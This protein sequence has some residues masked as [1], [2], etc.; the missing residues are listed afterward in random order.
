M[1]T[2]SRR[3]AAGALALAVAATL[4]VA[5][6]AGATHVKGHQIP[7]SAN[8]YK[9]KGG[10]VGQWKVTK[11]KVD[12]VTPVFR[13][14]GQ[15]TFKGC[16]DADRDGSCAGNATGKLYFKFRYWARFTSDDEVVLGTCAHRVVGGTDGFLGANGFL[17]MVDTPAG[18]AAGF[19]TYYEG[20]IDLA[21]KRAPKAP[22]C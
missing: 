11:F 17:M 13:G 1:R 5:A 20:D 4:A 2:I 18:N 19:S 22:R 15:E 9:M 21:G 14:H 7:V 3:G 8:K 12:R 6:P 16:L 10:L